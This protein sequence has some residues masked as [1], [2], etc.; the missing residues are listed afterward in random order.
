MSFDN[1]IFDKC[2]LCI[3]APKAMYK[4][5]TEASCLKTHK[6]A[7]A[8]FTAWHCK[9]PFSQGVNLYVMFNFRIPQ[10]AKYYCSIVVPKYLPFILPFIKHLTWA[11][12]FFMSFLSLSYIST[13]HLRQNF[14]WDYD[15]KKY[16]NKKMLDINRH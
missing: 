12:V 13:S 1:C 6:G 4:T 5:V 15:T 7:S 8:C 2:R 14:L 3:S 10:I 9:G 16:K 11:I